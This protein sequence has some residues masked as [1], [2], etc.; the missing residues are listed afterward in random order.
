[1]S[2]SK[3]QLHSCFLSNLKLNGENGGKNM[4][5]LFLGQIPEA[6]FYALFMIYSKRLKEKRF[7][8]TLLMVVEY[9]LT[10][11]SF[12]YSWLF[13]ITYMVSVFLTLKLLYKEKSQITD[14]FIFC[15]AYIFI[16]LASIISVVIG[17]F[18]FGSIIL[19]NT[20]CKIIMFSFI[21]IFKYRLTVIQNVYKKLW[22]RN[23]K[24]SK[25]IKTTTFRAINIVLF[26]LLFA[27][28]N[29]CMIYALYY[30][31]FVKGGM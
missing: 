20:I 24:I 25:K 27:I 18:I 4:L 16:V 22:N 15:I 12:Q 23:D 17:K 11:Y 9:L 14:I 8:F 1:M 3:A 19:A 2:L 13:H 26:N 30:N 5:Q 29:L 21:F 6:I 7:L 28:F 31:N 10:K